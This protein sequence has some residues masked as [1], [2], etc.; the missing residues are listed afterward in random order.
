M[1]FFKKWSDMSKE[2]KGAIL[3]AVEEGHEIEFLCFF[4]H[5]NSIEEWDRK[6]KLSECHQPMRIKPIW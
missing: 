1:S 6:S 5:K 2:E 4:L 3:L